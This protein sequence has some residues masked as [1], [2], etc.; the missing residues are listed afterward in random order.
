VYSPTTVGY[1]VVVIIATGN[2]MPR[3][4]ALIVI[5][6]AALALALTAC[7]NNDGAPPAPAASPTAGRPTVLV[8]MTAG[9]DRPQPERGTEALALVRVTSPD[10]T[11][12]VDARVEGRAEGPTVVL[13]TAED[14]TFV[15]G[16]ALLLFT[17]D[18]D[19]PVTMTVTRITLPTGDAATFHPSSTLTTTY[20]IGEVCTPP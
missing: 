7:H 16:E 8:S 1:D 4:R 5:S 20:D 17:V 11:P 3:T 13:D 12:V 6:A 2:R 10:G 18:Q 9:C 19:G 14:A 15:N